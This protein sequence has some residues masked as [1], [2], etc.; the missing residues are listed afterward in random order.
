M[1]LVEYETNNVQSSTTHD[2]LE[3]SQTNVQAR[4][5]CDMQLALQAVEQVALHK[6]VDKHYPAGTVYFQVDQ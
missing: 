3:K 2:Q 4:I 6:H 5:I 1:Q